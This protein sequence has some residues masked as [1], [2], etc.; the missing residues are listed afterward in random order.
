MNKENLDNLTKGPKPSLHRAEADWD[1][2]R[3]LVQRGNESLKDARNKKN[4]LA[5]RFAAA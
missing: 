5:T 4:S 2:L 3:G 1:V